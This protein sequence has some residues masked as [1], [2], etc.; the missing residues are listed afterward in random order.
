MR[1]LTFSFANI[2]THLARAE[3]LSP[4]YLTRDALTAFPFGLCNAMRT[5]GHLM[6]QHMYLPPM[7]D[8]FVGI[9]D[10]VAESFHHLLAGDSELIS[11]SD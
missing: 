9:A 7:D 2:M 4:K 10:Y 5:I 8:K 1:C 11:D 6:V 3:P